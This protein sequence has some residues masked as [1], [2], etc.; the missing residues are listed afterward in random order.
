MSAKLT[1]V[2]LGQVRPSC[3][4]KLGTSEPPPDFQLSQRKEEMGVFW[5]P[6]RPGCPPDPTEQDSYWKLASSPLEIYSG[7]TGRSG[8]KIIF[9][10]N[11][12]ARFLGLKS[13]FVNTGQTGSPISWQD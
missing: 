9:C 7:E 10:S 11:L 1:R 6:A 13:P 2:T 12:E 4:S 8:I 5:D 3:T